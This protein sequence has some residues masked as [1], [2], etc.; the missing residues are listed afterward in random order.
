MDRWDV[1]DLMYVS[2]SKKKMNDLGM[3]GLGQLFSEWNR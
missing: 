3:H 2:G 1:Y